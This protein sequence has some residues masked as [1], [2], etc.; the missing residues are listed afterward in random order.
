[1]TKATGGIGREI[2]HHYE[3]KPKLENWDEPFGFELWTEPLPG[4]LMKINCLSTVFVAALAFAGLLCAPRARATSDVQI[5]VQMTNVLW[6]PSAGTLD[7]LSPWELEASASIFDSQNG[8]TNGYQSLSGQPAAVSVSIATPL[9]TAGSSAVVD[10]GGNIVFL[11]SLLSETITPGVALTG[12]SAATAY[13]E[14]E[15]TGGSGSALVDFGF[16]FSGLFQNPTAANHDMDYT[17]LLRI[18]DGVNQWDLTAY[19]ELL[20]PGTQPF[21]GTLNQGFILQYNTP[22]SISLIKD[23]E[24]TPEPQP[25]L[26]AAI[27]IGLWATRQLF[28]ARK[29]NA[30]RKHSHQK[31][32]GVDLKND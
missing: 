15:I 1:M 3:R 13:R 21:G 16:G 29:F 28:R 23:T 8:F 22:Y 6:S 25:M 4:N 12:F 2:E 10:V 27:G 32:E 11:Q 9:T 7:W 24:I 30:K 19:Q 31:R 14:F 20:A 17:A 18:S 5:S 26:L